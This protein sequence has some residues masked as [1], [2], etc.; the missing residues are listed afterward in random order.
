[1]FCRRMKYEN[2][3]H[4]FISIINPLTSHGPTNPEGGL[5]QIIVSVIT[6]E[7]E[8][9]HVSWPMIGTIASIRLGLGASPGCKTTNICFSF[10]DKTL[11]N[12]F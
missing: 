6:P 4:K 12:R 10:I 2:S 7:S 9:L 3:T 8:A 5:V 11:R 1:M